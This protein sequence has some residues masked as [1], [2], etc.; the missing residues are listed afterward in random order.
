MIR[1][2]SHLGIAV[3]DM[4]RAVELYGSILGFKVSPP[5]ESPHLRVCMVDAGNCQIELLQPI[6]GEGPIG[7]FIEKKGEGI[8]HICFEVEDIK[9]VLQVLSTKGV[10]LIDRAPREGIEGQIAFIHPRMTNG[11]LIELVQKPQV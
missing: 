5:L 1:G 9:R 6:T 3:K 10:E 4:Q 2:I 7:R 11:V 8:Q